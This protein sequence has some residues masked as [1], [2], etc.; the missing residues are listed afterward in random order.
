MTRQANSPLQ[1][2]LGYGL[3][4]CLRARMALWTTVAVGQPASVP[5]ISSSHMCPF[6]GNFWSKSSS[7]VES[8]EFKCW[9]WNHLDIITVMKQPG[10]AHCLTANNVPMP[11]P[12][13]KGT[14][15]HSRSVSTGIPVTPLKEPPWYSTWVYTASLFVSLYGNWKNQSLK[16]GHKRCFNI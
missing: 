14:G 11:Q 3:W 6:L 15:R 12:L 8:L 9:V 7:P 5:I 1:C 10:W 13:A 4:N 16:L 2:K